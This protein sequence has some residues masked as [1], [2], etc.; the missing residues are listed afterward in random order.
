MG[1]VL[2]DIQDENLLSSVVSKVDYI[3]HTVATFEGKEFFHKSNVQTTKIYWKNRCKKM[4][5]SLQSKYDFFSVCV[6]NYALVP[7][8]YM[9]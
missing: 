1:L 2:G 6:I 7:K 5:D 9:G 3:I 4:N 8:N